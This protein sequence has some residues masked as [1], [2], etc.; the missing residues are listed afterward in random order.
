MS[1]AF[2]EPALALADVIDL[3]N[4]HN[5]RYFLVGSFA[6]GFRGEFRATNDLDIVCSFVPD[7]S[8]LFLEQAKRNFF[9]VSFVEE[10]G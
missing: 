9:L 6:S 8:A 4:A 2:F 7:S 1:K 5:I 10:L 3:F